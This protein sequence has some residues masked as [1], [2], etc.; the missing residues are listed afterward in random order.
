VDQA[1]LVSCGQTLGN[2]PADASGLG[3]RKM[4]WQEKIAQGLSFEKRHGQVGHAAIFP[5]ME[6]RHDVVVFD[7]RRCLGLAQK[8]ATVQIA[9]QA[10]AHHLQGNLAFELTIFRLD[11]DT[12]AAPSKDS[13]KAVGTQTAQLVRLL[14]WAGHALEFCRQIRML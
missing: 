13:E 1:A 8:P 2:L 10:R 11:D 4:A 9:R 14:G 7:G 3:Q 6:N 5:H 12:H